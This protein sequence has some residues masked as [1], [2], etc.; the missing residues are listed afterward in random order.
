[1]SSSPSIYERSL[2]YHKQPIPGK[3]AVVPTKPM[4]DQRDL[5]LA[6]SPGV[7]GPCNAIAEDPSQAAYLTS[8]ANL[9]AVISNGTAVLGLGNIGPLASKPVMEGKAVLFK[10]FAGI[11]VFDIEINETD[12]DKLVDIIASLE[13]TFGGIN[14]EDI[15]APECFYIE[16]K[17]TERMNIPVFHDD[18]HGTA[19]I[20]S[21]AILNGLRLVGKDIKKVK[22]VTSGAGAAALACV[23][24]LV[25]IGLNPKNV[26][27]CDSE[28]VVFKDRASKMDAS[29]ERY[30]ADTPHRTLGEAMVEA[31][32]FLGLSVAGVVSKEMV[33]GMAKRPLILALSNPEPEIRPEVVKEV[34]SDAVIATGRSDYPNQVNNVLCFPFIFRGALDVGATGINQEMKIACVKALA[35]LAHAE[36]SDIVA[37]AYGGE[38]QKFGD[39]YII[40]KPFDPRLAVEIP[41][42][43]AKAA[44]ETGIATRPIED[45]EVYKSHLTSFIYRSSLVM[46]PIF[47]QAKKEMMRITFAE[48]EEEKV[49]RCVQ[50]LCDEQICRPILVGRPNV[51]QMRIERLGLRLQAERDFDLIDPNNDSRYNTYW[52]AYHD[53]MQRKGI[54]PDIAKTI[55]HT[56]NTVIAA[57]TVHLGDADS[58]IAGTVGTYNQHLNDILDILKL[59]PDH[60]TVAAL[61]MVILDKGVY[62]ISD[63]YVN[64]SAKAEEIA[65]ITILAADQVKRFGIVP[66]VALL[67]HSNFGSSNDC[68]AVK[69]RKAL[70]ILMDSHPELE[71]DGE[72]HGD[73]ALSEVIRERIFPNSRL[74]G[75]AN[76]LIMPSVDSANITVNMLKVLADGLSVGPILMGTEKPGHI[77]TPTITVRG[78]IN[79]AALAAV[80]AQV[81]LA[82]K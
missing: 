25:A 5:A 56:N 48:G 66:K 44:M 35:E 76:L 43:V 68:S 70:E 37:N 8:R 34:R 58:M 69:M 57:L 14:L 24:L 72:M 7:A 28:G 75:E 73:A 78:L 62:F 36:S 47:A 41:V 60:D 10:K 46:R 42:V 9:I 30:A 20:V 59:S 63:A 49:L 19:I 45:F 81:R 6:Y 2:W 53:L 40:P 29:K 82:K 33:A 23:D 67:S 39:E 17:L 4:A 26:I 79:M 22:L 21:A 3:L 50:S 77:V 31:D 52:R 11:N 71:V 16:K 12:P 61:N 1:M 74:K 80:D 51:I 18:Q 38:V 32:I 54:T 55:M 15:K 27:I 13:P 64:H 65:E